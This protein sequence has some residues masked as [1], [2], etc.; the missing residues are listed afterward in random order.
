MRK[1]FEDGFKTLPEIV[2]NWSAEFKAISGKLK[3]IS[4]CIYLDYLST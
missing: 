2:Y 1:M 3:K 4:V